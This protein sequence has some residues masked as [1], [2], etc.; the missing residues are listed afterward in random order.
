MDAQ[1]SWRAVLALAALVQALNEVNAPMIAEERRISIG[2]TRRTGARDS[3]D[4]IRVIV[5]CGEERVRVAASRS[6]ARISR[7][8]WRRLVSGSTSSSRITS[9][10]SATAMCPG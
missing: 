8:Y 5:T 3:T 9:P 4:V 6:G 7:T 2:E 1:S 10:C